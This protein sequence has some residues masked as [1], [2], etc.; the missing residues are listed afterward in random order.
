[1]SLTEKEE[2]A[3][4][5]KLVLGLVVGTVVVFLA[6]PV[7][8]RPSAQENAT[9]TTGAPTSTPIPTP[10]PTAYAFR[11]LQFNLLA[12]ADIQVD[13]TGQVLVSAAT[14]ALAPGAATV[15]FRVEGATV[16]TVQTGKV[17]LDA[18]TAIVGVVDIAP[19]IG[20]YPIQGSPVAMDGV[21]ISAGQQVF[22]PAGTTGALRNE[23]QTPATLLI[24]SV[25]ADATAVTPEPTP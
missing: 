25:T 2:S 21:T 7:S 1:M 8:G 24:L 15:P 10:T 17:T 12:Q 11:A 9:A 3:V 18:D 13:T 19:I 5:A 16:I 20:L 23:Q 4:K 22:L 14:V 6:M